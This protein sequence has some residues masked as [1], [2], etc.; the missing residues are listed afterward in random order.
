MK[1]FT[2]SFLSILMLLLAMPL[3]AL[4]RTTVTF[5]FTANPWGLPTSTGSDKKGTITAPITQDGVVLTTVSNNDQNPNQLFGGNSP[6]LRVYNE[7]AFTFTAPEGKVIEKIEFVL[8]KSGDF[9]ATP[10]AGTYDKSSTTWAQPKEQVNAVKF[11]ATGTNKI[12]KA[13]LTIAD[14]GEGA[15]VVVLPEIADFASLKAA[16]QDKAVKLTVT[17]GKVVYAGSNDLIVEDATGAID[18]YNWGIKATAGQV[19]NGTVEAKYAEFFGMPQAAKTANT[20]VTALTITDGDAV[21]PVAMEFADAMKATSYLKYV[22]LTDFTIEEADGNT[23]LVNG[24]NKIQLYNKFKVEYT[25]PEAI[26]SISGIIIP[27]VAKGS[28]DVIVEIAP[29]SA[30]D[31]ED[32]VAKPVLPEGDVTAKYLVNPGFEDCEAATGKV[33]T[34]GSAQGTDYEAVGW[35]LVS[36][37]AWSNSAAFAYGSDASLNDAAVP[38]TD[39]AGNTGKALGFTVGWSGT[40]SYQSAA[41][42][43]LPVGYYT[44]KAHAYN[45]GTAT[46]FASKLGFATADNAYTSTK[47]S[48]ALNEWVEDVVEFTLESE[49]AGHFTIGGAAV[50]GGSGANGKVFFDN[51]TLERQDLFTAVNNNLA[52][53]I[54]AAKEI[55]NAGLAPTADLLAAIATAEAATTKT[56]YKE[57]LAA[58]EP[59]KAAVATYND[60]NA[61]FVAFADAK[62]KYA[63]IDTKYA[64]DEKIAA[65]NA[66]AEKT[67]ATADEADALKADY[68]KAVRSLVESNALAEG[69]E[70]ATNYT[71]SIKNPNAE[72]LDGWTIALGEINKGAIKVLNNEPFTDAE[73]NSTHSYF[74]GGSWNDNAWDVT[75]SQDVTLPKGKYLLT[76]TSRASAD[77]TS[78]A[79]F[80]GEAR[81]EMKHVGASGELFD[82]GWN[83]NSVEFE[84]AEDDAT[85][86]L[87][88]QGVTDKQHQWMSFTRFRL[89]KVGEVAP[90]YTEVN[91]IAELRAIKVESK[92]DEVPVKINLHDAKITA[93]HKTSDYGME[94]IDFAILEDATGA[95]DISNLMMQATAEGTLEGDFAEGSVLNGTLY[96][97]LN[98]PNSLWAS[99]DTEKSQITPTPST[100]VP[101]EATLA[102]AMKPENDLRLFKLQDVT[103]KNVGTEEAPDFDICQGEASIELRDAFAL[104]SSDG[105]NMPEKLQSVTGILYAEYESLDQETP[106]YFF[107]PLSYE[108]AP[109]A[110]IEVNSIAE[111]NKLGEENEGATIK[112]KLTDA[113]ITVADAYMNS[114]II[115]DKTGAFNA[116]YFFAEAVGTEMLKDEFKQGVVLNG[117]LYAKYSY[118]SIEV[119]ENTANSDIT[120]TE[121]PVVPTEADFAEVLKAENNFRLYEFKGIT[122]NKNKDDQFQLVKGDAKAEIADGTH[123]LDESMMATVESVVGY[124]RVKGDEAEFTLISYKTTTPDGISSIAVAAKNAAVYNLNGAKV[125]NIG[126]SVK[127]LAKGIYV[128]GGK[129]IFVK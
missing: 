43:V 31:I 115:E 56:D 69:V 33:A 73:G 94:M 7:S 8:K 126:E 80:A 111:L 123:S 1:K 27:F 64:S 92:W 10:D 108:A 76:A 121:A 122:V 72:A 89:V 9:A 103:I 41:E 32:I 74:D 107:T 13:V 5:D 98:W 78:F 125:R 54:A 46:Q 127:G 4:A 23:Y 14:P 114:A 55:A 120:T 47:N 85:V 51:I 53:E 30:E 93:L 68:I 37:A 52:K 29:T 99:E 77:L 19:I 109:A 118:G 25:L 66:I 40:N 75:F 101:T 12:S 58:I 60:V 124:F 106:K 63:T 116:Q 91:S 110:P 3:G 71:E 117:Y 96:A 119:C 36:S 48:F 17:N 81:A 39:N 22:T 42:V 102:E 20:D 104:W 87:G 113:Q 11:T 50:S 83:D 26:K 90:A 35:K 128:V 6:S 112:L 57:I 59:L 70:G 97:T 95:I 79:L 16:E 61:H 21:A 88:V 100:V 2:Y 24:E 67:P 28:T 45:G 18:F 38:A 84:V 105:S 129:K 82:R 62:A 65:V 86:N 49:T 44:L 34:A 15:E